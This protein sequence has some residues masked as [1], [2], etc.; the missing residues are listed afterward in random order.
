[1]DNVEYKAKLDQ[2]KE[3]LNSQDYEGALDLVE[4]IDWRRVKSVNTLCMVADI[5]EMNDMLEE[6]KNILLQAYRHSSIGKTILYRLVEIS[7][8]LGDIDEAVHYFSE[9][10][11]A[12]SNDN[13][14]YI[15]KYKI[16]RA[17]DA[18]ILDQIA[19]LEDYRRREFT[20]RWAYE[21]ALLYGKA[22]MIDKCIETCDDMI[23]WFSE[24]RYISKARELKS[25]MEFLTPEDIA[26]FRKGAEYSEV[27]KSVPSVSV[28]ENEKVLQKLD[29]ADAAIQRDAELAKKAAEASAKP[30]EAHEENYEFLYADDEDKQDADDLLKIHI[31][32]EY[33]REDSENT[34]LFSETSLLREKLASSFKD[35]F[36]GFTKNKQDNDLLSTFSEHEEPQAEVVDETAYDF[37]VV[38]KLEPE[39]FKHNSV[40]H[41]QEL[42]KLRIAVENERKEKEKAEQ[43][44]LNEHDAGRI[45]ELLERTANDL[46]QEILAKDKVNETI[47]SQAEEA[48]GVV[49]K[50]HEDANKLLFGDESELVEEPE[51]AEEESEAAEAE[52][53][54]EEPEVVEAEEAEE[55]PEAA[56]TEEVEVTEEESE[57]VETEE[58]EVTED[59]SE[60]AEAEEVEADTVEDESE[61]AEAEATETKSDAVATGEVEAVEI[62]ETTEKEE[63]PKKKGFGGWLKNLFSKAMEPE[64][65]E[66]SETAENSKT[67]EELESAEDLDSSGGASESE[68]ELQDV[69]DVIS[70]SEIAEAAENEEIDEEIIQEE[71][72]PEAEETVQ[73]PIEELEAEKE[74]AEPEETEETVQESAEEM[75]AEDEISET[76]ELV[77]EAVEEGEAEEIPEEVQE[78][79]EIIE[80]IAEDFDLAEYEAMGNALSDVELD[81]SQEIESAEE[82]D[83][84]IVLPEVNEKSSEDEERREAEDVAAEAVVPENEEAESEVLESEASEDE[85]PESEEVKVEAS[86]DEAPESEEVGDEAPEDE[87]SEAD[88][89]EIEVVEA[90]TSDKAD[91]KSELEDLSAELRMLIAAAD[92]VEE[93]ISE[94]P[95]E[96]EDEEIELSAEGMILAEALAEVSIFDQIFS[97]NALLDE[98]I[99]KDFEAVEENTEISE[100]ESSEEAAAVDKNENVEKAA[101][102]DES[103]KLEEA[104]AVDERENVEEVATVDESESTE[105]EVVADGNESQENLGNTIIVEDPTEGLVQNDSSEL[106]SDVFQQEKLTEEQIKIFSYFSIIPGMDQRLLN[107]MNNVYRYMGDK[108]SRRGNVAVMGRSGSGKSKMINCLINAIAS[109]MGLEAVKMA[110]VDGAAMNSKDPAK[111]V[112][113]MSGGF[114]VIENAGAMTG[115]TVQKLSDA[116]SFRTDGLVLF[117]EDDA[118]QMRQLLG[119]NKEF[120]AK[121]DSAISIPVLTNDELVAFAKIYAMEK[122][123]S[124]NQMGILALYTK[125]SEGQEKTDAL[126]IADVGILVDE[127]ILKVHKGKLGKKVPMSRIDQDGRI[128]IGE[129]DFK[130]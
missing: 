79:E 37:D 65:L 35:V 107:A 60:V 5:F 10:I 59:E 18:P 9:Y 130:N 3:M 93:E 16:F 95:Q 119:C 77:Q 78:D 52:E 2:I 72:I 40:Y 54:E 32:E 111:V 46:M 98:D 124:F 69:S 71:I 8:K 6:S 42:D 115:E 62:V 76:E 116:M 84:V 129:K 74:I 50:E 61:A 85:T 36:S 75:D 89:S 11:Q 12:A 48:L 33:D 4:T 7:L 80:E 15:L 19:I 112:S 90:E 91:E 100:A 126:T 125:I 121:I 87:E 44:T 99:D 122:G 47:Q 73:E 128:T 92:E 96:A 38:R 13:S 63:Q 81:Y 53:A 118:P 51:E 66:D 86:E 104:A 57:V 67:V 27:I 25:H 102:V 88:A 31:D 94:I 106:S 17:K 110:K 14:Q 26:K 43:N 28:R 113:L 83:T 24:G 105:K 1:M 21:L 108:T 45:Q 117:L 120:A 55:E 23:L 103:E 101:A 49:E 56:E 64:K 123:Y 127:A 109:G 30:M 82:S 22:G 68:A 70:E 41:T 114:L 39:N 97:D 34:S 20:E 29:Q 58:V